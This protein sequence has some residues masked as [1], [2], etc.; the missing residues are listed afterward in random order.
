MLES[1]DITKKCSRA[2]INWSFAHNVC[3]H[4]IKISFGEFRKWK[5]IVGG[6]DDS[7]NSLPSIGCLQ[8]Q[9][10]KRYVIKK[11]MREYRRR[12]KKICD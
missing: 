6:I 5:P 2:M 9:K 8:N 11:N 12:G 4:T 3:P 10:V 1:S 7:K